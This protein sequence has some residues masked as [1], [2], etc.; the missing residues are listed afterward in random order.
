MQRQVSKNMQVGLNGNIR[1]DCDESEARKI[2]TG[3]IQE[4]QINEVLKKLLT[5][6]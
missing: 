2:M 6:I 3:K 5:E 4:S 1:I